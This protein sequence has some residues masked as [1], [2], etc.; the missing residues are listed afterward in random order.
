M[1]MQLAAA[2]SAQSGIENSVHSVAIAAIVGPTNFQVKVVATAN[3][4]E[5]ERPAFLKMLNERRGSLQSV[6]ALGQLVR[7]P[8][9]AVPLARALLEEGGANE[10]RDVLRAFGLDLPSLPLWLSTQEPIARKMPKLPPSLPISPKVLSVRNWVAYQG[11]EMVAEADSIAELRRLL[12]R[13]VGPVTII[14]GGKS[15]LG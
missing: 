13:P 3:A 10:A 7:Y 15:D 14:R 6:A 9:E 2:L 5:V 4:I 12:G 8:A 1:I 11:G